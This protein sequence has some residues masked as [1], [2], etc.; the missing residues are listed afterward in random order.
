MPPLSTL[1][2]FILFLNG[3]QYHPYS[4]YSQSYNVV[5]LYI[6]RISYIGGSTT[7]MYVCCTYNTKYMCIGGLLYVGKFYIHHTSQIYVFNLCIYFS[8]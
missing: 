2:I 6:Y 4:M 7:L 8:R 1:Y 5:Y 3:N